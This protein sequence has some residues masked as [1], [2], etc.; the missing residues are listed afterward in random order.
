[1]KSCRLE[2]YLE[3]KQQ[4]VPNNAETQNKHTFEFVC[5][6]GVFRPTLEFFSCMEN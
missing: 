4:L 3:N 6:F 5:L 2:I 1:M